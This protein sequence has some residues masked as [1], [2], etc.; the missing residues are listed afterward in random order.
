MDDKRK[1]SNC[2]KETRLS[3]ALVVQHGGR[4]IA[5]IC[6][7]CQQA[8]KVQVTFEKTKKGWKFFQY[9]PLEG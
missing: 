9:F 6:D 3:H 5:V 8:K 7:G 1:C 2:Q 4:V